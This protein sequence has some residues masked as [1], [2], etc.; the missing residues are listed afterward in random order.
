MTE[1][2]KL[3]IIDNDRRVREDGKFT[4]GDS[5]KIQYKRG[6]SENWNPLIGPT[7]FIEKKSWKK[8]LLFGERNW[9]R[10][11][12]VLRKGDRCIDFKTEHIPTPNSD[13][14]KKANAR[15]LANN[16]GSERES[17]VPWYVWANLIMLA[18]IIAHLTGLFA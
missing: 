1:T 10:E 7:T 16:I 17:G 9:K 8:Y 15:A 14:L 11:Y 18:F 3:F 6:G 2:I 12:Y 4:V 13:E 5:G